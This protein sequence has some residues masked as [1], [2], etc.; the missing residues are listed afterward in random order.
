M[1]EFH[2]NSL[3]AGSRKHAQPSVSGYR[4]MLNSSQIHLTEDSDSRI[5]SIFAPGKE[6]Y[7][8]FDSL[9]SVELLI[10][11]RIE[12]ERTVVRN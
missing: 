11:E 12:S 10:K 5:C 9:R 7:F 6:N 3:L 1:T 4:Y 2:Q 8:W